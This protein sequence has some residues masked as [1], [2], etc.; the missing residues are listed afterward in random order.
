VPHTLLH[1]HAC[2]HTRNAG[3]IWSLDVRPDGGGMA[4]GSA[5][6]QVLTFNLKL[7]FCASYT[8]K[9][10]VEA[11]TELACSVLG[12]GAEPTRACSR[13]SRARNAVGVVSSASVDSDD[14]LPVALAGAQC[15]APQSTPLPPLPCLQC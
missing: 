11:V 1:R 7:H 6:G 3:A 8:L 13:R 12:V 10:C 9:C 5:D 2:T 15:G 4:T 14:C